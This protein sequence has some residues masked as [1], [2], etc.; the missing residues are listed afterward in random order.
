T[1]RN[2]S[3]N[4]IEHFG[5]ADGI[6]QPIFFE[7]VLNQTTYKWDPRAGPNLILVQDPHGDRTASGTY[8][9]FRKLEQNVRA[10]KAREKALAKALKLRKEHRERAGGMVVGRFE[11]GTPIALHEDAEDSKEGFTPENDFNYEDDPE[12]SSCPLSAHIRITNPRTD[13]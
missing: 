4:P 2:A 8:F 3:E 9:V 11:N 5:Y 7:T 6:S 1:M 10:F 13:A 12:G